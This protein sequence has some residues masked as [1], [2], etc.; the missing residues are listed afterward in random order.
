MCILSVF[1]LILVLG[2]LIRLYLTHGADHDRL[3]WININVIRYGMNFRACYIGIN[4][5]VWAG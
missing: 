2:M 1:R 3:W 5:T 4:M